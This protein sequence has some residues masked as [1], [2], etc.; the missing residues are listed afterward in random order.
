MKNNNTNTDIHLS[1]DINSNVLTFDIPCIVTKSIKLNVDILYD[2]KKII[3]PGIVEQL[4]INI[5]QI[6]K[7]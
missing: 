7:K 2:R 6:E 3:T 5:K 4:K 1:T